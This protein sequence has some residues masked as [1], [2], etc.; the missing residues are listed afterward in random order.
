MR[1]IALLD[2][3]YRERQSRTQSGTKVLGYYAYPV[4][5]PNG[6]AGGPFPRPAPS[7]D[8]LIAALTAFT[9]PRRSRGGGLEPPTA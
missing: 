9:P 2:L 7:L 8:A 4:Q 6:F 3:R 5:P 1:C